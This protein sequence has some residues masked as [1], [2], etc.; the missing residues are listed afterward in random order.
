MLAQILFKNVG[1]VLQ[2]T[3]ATQNV[4]TKS[5]ERLS[6]VIYWEVVVE[7]IRLGFEFNCWPFS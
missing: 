5:Y 7:I 6:Y 3:L 4:H 1:L 2:G